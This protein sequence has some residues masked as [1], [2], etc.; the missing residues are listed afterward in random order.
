M[1]I[2]LIMIVGLV[3]VFGLLA[4]A[5]GVVKAEE[6]AIRVGWAIGLVY[7]LSIILLAV[8]IIEA[9]RECTVGGGACEKITFVTQ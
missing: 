7:T 2:I 6:E 3:T 4:S 8:P 5:I 1:E 9:K